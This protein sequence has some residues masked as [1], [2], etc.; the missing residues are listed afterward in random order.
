MLNYSP[1]VVPHSYA[2]PMR[3]GL[4]SNYRFGRI[5][6]AYL[7]FFTRMRQNRR[8]ALGLA[9]AHVA[10]ASREL[11]PPSGPSTNSQWCSTLREI[12]GLDRRTP[13]QNAIF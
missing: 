11:P 7:V 8:E 9:F 10:R 3:S 12:T 6:L 2:I 1:R 4:Y 13:A 5:G